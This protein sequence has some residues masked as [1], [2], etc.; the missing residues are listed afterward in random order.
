MK[1]NRG[2]FVS[3][4]NYRAVS[5]VRYGAGIIRWSKNELKALDRKT[6]SKLLTI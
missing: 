4:I 5:S 1:L 3:A 2:N 6:F